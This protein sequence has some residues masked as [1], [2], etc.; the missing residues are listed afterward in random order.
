MTTPARE[1]RMKWGV[2]DR[3]DCFDKTVHVAPVQESGVI[4]AGHRVLLCDCGPRQERCGEF[5][6]VIHRDES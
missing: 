4:A 3:R 2:F 5:V 6:L 1:V